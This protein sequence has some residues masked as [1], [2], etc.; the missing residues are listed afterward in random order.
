M[1]IC[2]VQVV[3]NLYEFLSSAKHKEDILK[4]VGNNTVSGT[5][6]LP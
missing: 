5:H 6:W 3:P 4:Y 2:Q 1:K